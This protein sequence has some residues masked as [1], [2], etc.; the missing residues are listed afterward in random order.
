VRPGLLGGLGGEAQR[1]SQPGQAV[2][3]ASARAVKHS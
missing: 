3:D 2:I 1:R